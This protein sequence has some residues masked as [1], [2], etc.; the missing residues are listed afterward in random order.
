MSLELS[1]QIFGRFSYIKFNENP[2][3]ATS[4]SMRTDRRTEIFDDA[5]SHFSQFCKHA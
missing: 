1:R 4:C 2:S 5:N 3:V